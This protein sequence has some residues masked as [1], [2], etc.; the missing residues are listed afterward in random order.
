MSKKVI[1][2]PIDDPL[3]ERLNEFSERQQC[4]RSELIRNACLHLL[5]HLEQEEKDR[6][7]REGYVKF[8]EE[9]TAGGIQVALS[10]FVLPKESW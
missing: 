2:V 10:P 9:L 3:L 5:G 6:L 1:Q 4:T 7:Y 8:P